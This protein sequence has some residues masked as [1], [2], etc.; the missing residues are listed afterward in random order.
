M[1]LLGAPPCGA[2]SYAHGAVAVTIYV[3]LDRIEKVVGVARVR[4]PRTY[5]H[6]AMCE[7]LE[8]SIGLL[9]YWTT[10][11]DYWTGLLDSPKLQNTPRSV[12]NGS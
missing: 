7:L 8:P 12:Q 2:F 5:L 1:S 11:L 3:S 4:V 9:D 6:Y 10:G